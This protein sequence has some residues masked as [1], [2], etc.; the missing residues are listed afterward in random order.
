MKTLNEYIEESILDIDDLIANDDKFIEDWL[1]KNCRLYGP[2]TI[3]NSVVDVN[4]SVRI[5]KNVK[6]IDIQ[7]GNVHGD[8]DCSECQKLTS[9]EGC[10]KWVE[11]DFDCSGCNSLTSLE[12]APEKVEHIFWCKNCTK[13]E[14]LK[15]APKSVGGSFLCTSCVKLKNLKGAPE[16]VYTYFE[17]SDCVNLESLEGSPR[18]VQMDFRLSRCTKLKILK[19]ITQNI[20]GVIF[21]KGCNLEHTKD[22]PKNTK[23]IL[24]ETRNN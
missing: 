10:P 22:A 13:L 19:G 15:G 16:F 17:C 9:L 20:G 11:Y 4:G 3:K 18:H 24:G 8:F 14:T 6:S 2:Y 7:F 23:I 21:A 5:N 1:K 12:G